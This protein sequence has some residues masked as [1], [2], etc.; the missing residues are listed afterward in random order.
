MLL[1]R[2]TIITVQCRC[3]SKYIIII[4]IIFLC[5]QKT[6][7]MPSLSVVPYNGTII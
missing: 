6:W 3:L 2:R 4:N 5:Y 7:K 1:L